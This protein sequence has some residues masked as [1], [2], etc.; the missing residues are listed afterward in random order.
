M[1]G[2]VAR[3]GVPEQAELGLRRRDHARRRL[4][5]DV[6]VDEDGADLSDQSA[7]EAGAADH[8]LP[9]GYDQ[10]ERQ[11]NRTFFGL[12]YGLKNSLSFRLRFLTPQKS[13]KKRVV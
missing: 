13:L 10:A 2:G 9:V 1:D 3:H 12:N 11:F 4:A 8:Q 7:L 6:V 5:R